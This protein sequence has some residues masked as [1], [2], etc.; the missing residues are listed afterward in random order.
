[1]RGTTNGI[2]TLS[3]KLRWLLAR[4]TPP[5]AGTCSSPVTV[6]RHT[7]RATGGTTRCSTLY[8]P[9]AV[10]REV[11]MGTVSPIRSRGVAAYHQQRDVV[12]RAALDQPEQVVAQRL[13]VEVAAALDRA[14]E[15]LEALVQRDPAALDEA[16][17]V[18]AA[19]SRPG[20]A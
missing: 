4:I 7:A 5:V 19:A 2:T 6:G 13:G 16:V 1:M 12:L 14:D 20:P 10:S 8:I 17:G 3:A 18:D 11:A 9:G 15:P